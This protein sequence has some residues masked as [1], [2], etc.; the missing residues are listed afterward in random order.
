PG[1]DSIL[2]A[3]ENKE[4]HRIRSKLL[5][6]YGGKGLG[7]QEIPVDEAI[8][9]FVHLINRKYVTTNGQLKPKPMDGSHVFQYFSQDANSAIEFGKPFGYLEMNSDFNGIM[10]AFEIM[11]PATN[12]LALFPSIL[13]LI[14]TRVG[15][16]NLI[17][18]KLN[19]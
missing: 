13:W 8:V 11:I 16:D 19:Q 4:H 6:G 9:N 1:R 5:P 10:E 2:T 12:V 14:K 17:A 3:N 15:D 18:D 7:N